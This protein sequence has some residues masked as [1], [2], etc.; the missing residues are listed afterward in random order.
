M[1]SC[2]DEYQL[3]SNGILV[4]C[5]AITTTPGQSTV[6]T[7][8]SGANYIVTYDSLY[9][10]FSDTYLSCTKCIGV[11]CIHSCFKKERNGLD[12]IFLSRVSV[13]LYAATERMRIVCQIKPNEITSYY[14]T[15][16]NCDDCQLA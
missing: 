15:H 4:M 2:S 8:R 11:S 3:K 5:Y 10:N 13:S 6:K 16:L 9:V 12:P 14:A 1:L 7:C